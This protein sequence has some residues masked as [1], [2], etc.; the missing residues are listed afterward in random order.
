VPVVNL[1][2]P[3]FVVADIDSASEAAATGR[4]ARP[5]YGLAAAVVGTW[6]LGLIAS[7]LAGQLIVGGVGAVG[8]PVMVAICAVTAVAR[9]ASAALAVPLVRRIAGNLTRVP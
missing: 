4:A 3:V 6:S 1:V 2:L 7:V 5:R 9:V 8:R